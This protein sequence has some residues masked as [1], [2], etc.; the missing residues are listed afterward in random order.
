MKKQQKA[1]SSDNSSSSDEAPTTSS[2]TY[3]TVSTACT[4][5]PPLDLWPQLFPHH[6]EHEVL[7]YEGNKSCWPAHINVA[8]PFVAQ[9]GFSVAKGKLKQLLKEHDIQ[10]FDIELDELDIFEHTI[11]S[12]IVMK[13][14]VWIG[15]ERKDELLIQLH[16]LIVEC[17]NIVE[18][19]EYVPHISISYVKTKDLLKRK[20]M[21]ET[22]FTKPIRFTVDKLHFLATSN[23]N[24]KMYSKCE[25]F[26]VNGKFIRSMLGVGLVR[27][28]EAEEKVRMTVSLLL[29]C[30]RYFLV[31]DNRALLSPMYILILMSSNTM[32]SLHYTLAPFFVTFFLYCG[33]IVH[34]LIFSNS[35]EL[36]F[37]N[38][39]T[40]L[41]IYLLSYYVLSTSSALQ[42]KI[43]KLEQTAKELE[44]A[45]SSKEVFIRHISHEFR[46]P[47]LSSLGSVELLRETNL[48]EYQRELVETIAS[49]DGILL[50]LIE[51]VL[52]LVKIEHEKKSDDK[53]S[54]ATK[55][56]KI[57][58]LNNC[59]KMMGNIIKSYSKQFQVNVNV[60]IDEQAKDL[61]VRANQTRIH[62]VISNLMTNGVKASKIG[63][64]IDLE[65]FVQGDERQ[66]NGVIE[67][68]IIF[69]VKDNGI[70]IPKSKQAKIF[71]PFAQLHNLNQSIIPGSGLGLSTVK[72]NVQ[73][74]RGD[75]T[76]ESDENCGAEFTV[77]LPLEIVQCKLE[78]SKNS[79][80]SLHE[81][82]PSIKRQLAIQENYIRLFS[83]CCQN[84]A[85]NSKAEILIADDNSVN[86]RVI[87]KLIESLGYSVDAA[88]DGKEL[89]ELFDKGRHKLI[90]TDLNMPVLDGV[91]ATKILR[92]R[93]Q[94]DIKVVALTGDVLIEKSP[95]FDQLLTKPIHKLVLKE[96]IDSLMK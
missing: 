13:P 95:L 34:S 71:E 9:A 69:K 22:L 74:M 84:K 73:A 41:C 38:L 11:N 6:P 30:F 48:T 14:K 90:I 29:F 92:N 33:T 10:P 93:H 36:I 1:S 65:C 70:G 19:H 44:M 35:I 39:A 26:L 31:A 12:I 42:S 53:S 86:R 32:T 49:S 20:K 2:S 37:E 89:I 75:I 45:L 3:T 67:R 81:I 24:G 59:V 54:E 57:F 18:N 5:I 62:Q 43:T 8:Y 68:D 17:F 63:D 56:F 28:T 51:D 27:S 15:D 7:D 61:F 72:H 76:L 55:F 60:S 94:G 58:S 77:I 64:S 82:D 66:V 83:T 78:R 96:C 46:S 79:S 88:N 87:T 23:K 47:C 80:E 4:I 91:E 50:N 52:T 40:A 16:D 85:S 21:L 25:V